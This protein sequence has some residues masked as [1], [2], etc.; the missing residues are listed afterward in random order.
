MYF[1]TQQEA[2]EVHVDAL[3]YLDKEFDN[4]AVRARVERYVVR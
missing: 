3:P 2:N 1:A 4:P